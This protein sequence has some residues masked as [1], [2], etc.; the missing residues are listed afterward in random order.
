MA[1]LD[2]A[3]DYES[4]DWGFES[5]QGLSFY[6]SFEKKK[7]CFGQNYIPD[8]IRTHNL[9]LRK[10]TPCPFGHW[11]TSQGAPSWLREQGWPWPPAGCKRPEPKH[12][13]IAQ[14]GERQTE[15]LKVAG[16][17]PAVGIFLFLLVRAESFLFGPRSVARWAAR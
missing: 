5:L 2:K 13:G 10:P 11:D 6:F 15:D 17:I 1:Q 4:E 12:A 14:L 16:S 3:S 7:F 8:G 9:R